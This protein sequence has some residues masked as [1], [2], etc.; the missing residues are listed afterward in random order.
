MR[1]LKNTVRLNQMQA[2]LY[3]CE[4]YI[5]ILGNYYKDMSMS[6]R[7]LELYITRMN[8]KG[9]RYFF[10]KEYGLYIGF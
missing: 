4:N 5:H 2:F 9:S 7:V 1:I 3:V 6:N 8:I 10:S